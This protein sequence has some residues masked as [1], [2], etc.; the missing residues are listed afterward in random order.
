MKKIACLF[1]VFCLMAMLISCGGK[2]DSSES[3]PAQAAETEGSESVQTASAVA[4]ESE[5]TQ[6]ASAEAE[7]KNSVPTIDKTV[8]DN[9]T[10]GDSNTAYGIGWTR[11]ILRIWSG[12]SFP[13]QVGNNT[14]TTGFYRADALRRK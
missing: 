9:G 2:A 5:N 13:Y 6:A 10:Y 1:A 11:T 12:R 14:G 3:A 8:S 7:E 4:D